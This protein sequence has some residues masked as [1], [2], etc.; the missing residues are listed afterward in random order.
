MKL[1]HVTTQAKVKKYHE[2][3]RIIAPVRGFD[4]PMAAM[5]W[6]IKVGRRV[7][8]EVW[9]GDAHKLPDH[10]NKFGNAWWND[11][12]IHFWECFYSGHT[13]NSYQAETEKLQKEK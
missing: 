9:A 12:D 13:A 8:L 5:A 4:T 2:S 11:N 10:H 3:G 7:I 1:Y 6:A